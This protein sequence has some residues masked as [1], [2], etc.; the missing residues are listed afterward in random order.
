MEGPIVKDRTTFNFSARRTYLDLLAAIALAISNR[1]E[2]EDGEKVK[3]G[4][5]FHDLNLKVTHRFSDSCL[6]YTSRCV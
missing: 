2:G 6:L 4:Y 1:Q 5:N 3:G